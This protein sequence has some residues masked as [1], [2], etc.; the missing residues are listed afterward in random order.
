[1]EFATRHNEGKPKWSLVDF[2]ALEGLVR[3]LEFGSAK[4]GDYNYKKGFPRKEIMDSLLRHIFAILNGEEIDPESGLSH[5]A[6]IQA[7]AMFLGLTNN[8]N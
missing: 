7:N 5:V 8:V 1:M 4:Y 3:V 2:K 6:H